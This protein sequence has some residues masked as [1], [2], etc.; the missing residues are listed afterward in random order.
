MLVWFEYLCWNIGWM[1]IQFF[2]GNINGAI[3]MTYWIRIHITYRGKCV[4][5]PK[6]PLIQI[7]KNKCIETVGLITILGILFLFKLFISYWL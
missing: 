7:I 6:L 3:E 4:S 5:K 2:K 1:I